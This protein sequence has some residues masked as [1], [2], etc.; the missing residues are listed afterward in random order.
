M[1]FHNWLIKDHLSQQQQQQKG[2][3]KFDEMTEMACVGSSYSAWI[4]VN[5]L[6]SFLVAQVLP[7][8]IGGKYEETVGRL[9][10]A[11]DDGRVGAHYRPAEGLGDPELGLD[12]VRVELGVLEVG[13]A[14]RARHLRK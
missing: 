1:E 10:A 2:E 11:G 8:A 14:Q 5:D 7:Q 6:D 9:K 4:A 13:V 3:K 12:L